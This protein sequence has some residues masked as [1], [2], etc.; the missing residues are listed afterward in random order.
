LLTLLL[1]VPIA[2]TATTISTT[3][4]NL[5]LD[6]KGVPVVF[7][8]DPVPNLT[9]TAALESVMAG[10]TVNG[11][12]EG[13]N[14]ATMPTDFDTGRYVITLQLRSAPPSDISL[15]FSGPDTFEGLSFISLLATFDFIADNGCGPGCGDVQGEF[16][17][18]P[19]FD[20]CVGG[21]FSTCDV[22]G[23]FTFTGNYVL[24]APGVSELTDVSVAAVPEPSSLLLAVLGAAAMLVR[25]RF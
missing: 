9:L 5:T 17:S 23:A 4:G 7:V 24:G 21:G 2:L 12:L 1:G 14:F 25:K 22:A 13:F 8:P 18:L 16:G 15:S 10:D 19:G 20:N 11:V 6:L 3:T